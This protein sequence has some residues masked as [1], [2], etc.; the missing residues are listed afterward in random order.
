MRRQKLCSEKGFSLIEALVS[1]GTFALFALLIQNILL[2]GHS[3]KMS[4]TNFFDSFQVSQTIKQNLCIS[5]VSFKNL[6][7]DPEKS[8]ST[9]MTPKTVTDPQDSSKQK[10]YHLR[11]YSKIDKDFI[12]KPDNCSASNPDSC[13]PTPILQIGTS[14]PITVHQDSHTI[15]IINCNSNT[16]YGKGDEE[17]PFTSGHVFVSRCVK[18]D[19]SSFKFQQK[20]YKATFNPNS[21]IASAKSILDIPYKP[22]YFPTT[23]KNADNSMAETVFC[24]DEKT[25]VSANGVDK[26]KCVS[27]IDEYIPRIYVIHIA[28][29]P[30]GSTSNSSESAFRGKVE[31][32]QEI[33]EFQELNNIWGAGFV[34][35]MENKKVYH[36]TAFQLDTIFLKNTCSTNVAH[37]KNCAKLEMGQ[38]PS[39]QSLLN[40]G[41]HLKMMQF[42]QPEISACAN[43]S[44]T[45]DSTS[46]IRLCN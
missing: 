30:A 16:L 25:A 18:N 40:V 14:D 38:K 37:V 39:A 9:K 44:S 17:K 26:Q 28:P 7:I 45:V 3:I 27:A 35:S 46:F 4:Q 1:I 42:I 22:F 43:F 19:K 36:D 21:L 13:K 24:C 32:I 2:L 11:Q 41:Q 10:T 23:E 8:Y 34:L 12:P 20:G 31:A 29:T 5:N 15:A 6:Y 33:P